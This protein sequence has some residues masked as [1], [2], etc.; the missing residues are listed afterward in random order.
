MM[1]SGRLMYA[2][3]HMWLLGD[4]FVKLVLS[5]LLYVGSK[6]EAQV[7]RLASQVFLYSE[8]SHCL[9]GFVFYGLY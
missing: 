6:D 2:E 9:T 1:Q 4:N 7:I 8:T 5:F 3:E